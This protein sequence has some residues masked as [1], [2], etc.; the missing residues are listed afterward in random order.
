MAL[1]NEKLVVFANLEHE[2][3]PCGQLTLEE[4]GP[5]LVASQFAYGVNY[6]KRANA[7][8]VDPVSLSIANRAAVSDQ[9]LLPTASL[10]FLVAS[11]IA[12]RMRGV[13]V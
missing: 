13:G 2:W 10:P 11:E 4:Q 7:L 1:K 9:L 6:L 3:V 5:Q 8:E 12:L